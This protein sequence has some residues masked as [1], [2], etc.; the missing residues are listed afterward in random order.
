MQDETTVCTDLAC[1]TDEDLCGRH[2]AVSLP[3]IVRA[4]GRSR[5]LGSQSS[6]VPPMW[7]LCFAALTL[8]AC[9]EFAS[10]SQC[11]SRWLPWHRLM[12]V[13]TFNLGRAWMP[14]SLAE[15]SPEWISAFVKFK[16]SS[17]RRHDCCT[18]LGCEE[19]LRNLSTR[20]GIN[21]SFVF[22]RVSCIW[23]SSIV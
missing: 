11:I 19:L 18:A 4:L 23:Y 12:V 5:H 6:R 17:F 1:L 20:A 21:D 16:Q 2:V 14:L 22:C 13:G 3:R 7:I 9:I 8:A 15:A 10:A